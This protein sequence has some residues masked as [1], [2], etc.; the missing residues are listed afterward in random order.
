[1]WPVN[2]GDGIV[3]HTH[4]EFV[5]LGGKTIARKGDPRYV[6]STEYVEFEISASQK[7]VG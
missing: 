7:W 3:R 4:L 2:Y 5:G 6:G 1:M